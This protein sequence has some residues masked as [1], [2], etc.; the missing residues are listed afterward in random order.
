MIVS[1]FIWLVVIPLGHG[2]LPWVISLISVR[3]GWTDAHASVWNLLG[4]IPVIVAIPGLLWVM[5]VGLVSTPQRVEV[6]LTP[7]VLLVRG[8]YA[9]T[10]N[11]MYIGELC[12][13]FGWAV[14]YGSVFVF[15]GFVIIVLATNFVILPRE[16][17]A[18]ESH[19]GESYKQ[20]KNSVPRWL[21]KS[22]GSRLREAVDFK[23]S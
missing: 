8:P 3:Y 15:T 9:Y 17:R 21:G 16:E 18:L 14:Y 20:Y 10:R 5:V 22:T 4:L 19:L 7:Q 13:W 23:K 1:L 12:L 6:G 2:V 11:P